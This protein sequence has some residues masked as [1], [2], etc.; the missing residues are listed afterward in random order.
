[1]GW[2]TAWFEFSSRVNGVNRRL[3][4]D[5]ADSTL[6]GKRYCA[7]QIIDKSDA[8]LLFAIGSCEPAKE[9]VYQAEDDGTPKSGGE[10]IYPKSRDER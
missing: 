5:G 9:H 3:Q 6:S 7:L 2:E 1:M 4:L 10:S 8:R